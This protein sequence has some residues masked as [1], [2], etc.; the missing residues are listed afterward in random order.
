MQQ[1]AASFSSDAGKGVTERGRI[2]VFAHAPP[3]SVHAKKTFPDVLADTGLGIVQAEANCLTRS[4][5]A[6][7]DIGTTSANV[8]KRLPCLA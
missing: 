3:L 4:A 8:K 6:A 2:C 7:P 1:R 5:I